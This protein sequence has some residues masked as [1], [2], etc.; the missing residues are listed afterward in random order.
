MKHKIHIPY[1]QYGFIESESENIEELIEL[2]NRFNENGQKLTE[3]EQ[4]KITVKSFNEDIEVDK[5]GFSYY[6]K[7]KKLLSPSSWMKQYYKPFDSEFIAK[8]A[9]KAYGIEPKD[10]LKL[11]DANAKLSADFGTVIHNALEMRGNFKHIGSQIIESKEKKDS[12]KK[13]KDE[14]IYQD[15]SLSKQPFLQKVVQE[16]EKLD[17]IKGDSFSEVFITDVKNGRCGI[18]DMLTITGDMRCVI[19]DFKVQ[20]GV[21]EKS[22]SDKPLPPYDSLD[23]NKLSKH[24]L[25]LSYYGE[26]LEQTGWTI[27]KLQTFAYN[28]K[29]QK[30]DFKKLEIK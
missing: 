15:P 9:A 1:C 3:N 13:N 26:I 24:Q 5:I 27:D 20:V 25:Q 6:Y 21:E 10:L 12:K 22:S 19:K 14:I 7:G 2:N 28:G 17:K 18:V 4:T 16:F 8:R 23:S 30:Y 11:W 29:W